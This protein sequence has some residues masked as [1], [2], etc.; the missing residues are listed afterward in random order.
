MAGTT[1]FFIRNIPIGHGSSR[2]RFLFDT[3]KSG[4]ALA[5]PD[6]GR[7]EPEAEEL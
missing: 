6:L 7:Q 5:T 1:L 4:E 3:G 2:Y